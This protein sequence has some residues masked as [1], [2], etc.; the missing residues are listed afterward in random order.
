MI[1]PVQ[2]HYSGKN[3]LKLWLIHIYF[4]INDH[5]RTCLNEESKSYI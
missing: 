2:Y 4:E 3:Q 5:M 1:L